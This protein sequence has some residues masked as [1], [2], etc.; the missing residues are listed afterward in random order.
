MA[1]QVIAWMVSGFYF[2]IFPIEEIRG[3]H[4]TIAPGPVSVDMLG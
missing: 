3:E 4:L 1:V 2:S